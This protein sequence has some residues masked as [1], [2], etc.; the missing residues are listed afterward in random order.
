M[1]IGPFY[2]IILRPRI[3]YIE[4]YKAL[5]PF[6]TWVVVQKNLLNNFNALFI[7]FCSVQCYY[8]GKWTNEVC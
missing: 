6:H 8:I 5:C 1:D 3:L 7:A 2:D 4:R